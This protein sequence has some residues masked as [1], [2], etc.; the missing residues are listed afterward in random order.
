MQ[1]IGAY[2]VEIAERLHSIQVWDREAAG[3]VHM[4]IEECGFGYRDSVFKSQ[5]PGHRIILGV[6]LALPKR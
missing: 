5:S 6:T 4:P 2:G 3:P 1:N